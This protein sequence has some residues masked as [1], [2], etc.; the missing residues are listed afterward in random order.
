M[1][2]K[3]GRMQALLDK[4]GYGDVEN[5]LNEWNYV[6]GWT[7]DFV[8]SIKQII[9]LKGASF[10]LACMIEG[11]KSSIDMLMYYDARPSAFNGLFDFYTLEPLK[12]YYPFLWY[13]MLYGREEVRCA[14]QPEHIYS[15][16]GVDENGKTLTLLTHYDEN[17]DAADKTVRLDF[18][19]SASY[20]VYVLDKDHDATLLCETDDL[21]FSLPVHTCL[22]IKEK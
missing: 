10:S 1:M 9:G 21:T 2:E 14:D 13:G 19:R 20:E 4:Y 3:N 17:D 11:Q 15:L 12:G 6:R 16:C 22:L 7:D 5:I 8:Y 18:G